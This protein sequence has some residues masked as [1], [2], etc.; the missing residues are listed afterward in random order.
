[1]RNVGHEELKYIRQLDAFTQSIELSPLEEATLKTIRNRYVTAVKTRTEY[2]RKMDWVR[3]NYP[4]IAKK[5]NEWY[6]EEYSFIEG[7]T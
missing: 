5:V 6:R 7:G 1:M 3:L 2:T 4:D